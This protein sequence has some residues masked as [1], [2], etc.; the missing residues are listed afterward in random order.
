MQLLWKKFQ[1]K[2]IDANLIECGIE[3]GVPNVGYRYTVI[4]DAVL[5]IVT[6]GEGTFKCSGIEHKLKK[7]D[8]FL[9]KKDEAVEYYPSFSKPWTYY[10]LGMSGKQIINYLNRCQIIDNYVIVNKDTSDIKKIIQTV[11]EL[12][13]TIGSQNASDI[14]IMQNL[15]HLVYKLQELFPKTF[16]T[17]IEIINE[18]IQHAVDFINTNYNNNIMVVDVANHVNITRSHLFKLFKKNLNCS[19]KDYLTYIRMYH[20]S[21]LL[22]NTNLMICEIALKVGYKDPLLFSKIF[23]KHFEI[24]A[25]KYRINFSNK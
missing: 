5:H 18:D 21:Q 6:E 25:S 3:I 13:K 15:Y 19:P 12:S 11:C 9:L 17:E 7:G 14:L 20:A 23:T 8:M 24:S 1:K 4:K 16:S 2:H 22:I 10:W